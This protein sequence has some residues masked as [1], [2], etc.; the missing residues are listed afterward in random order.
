MEA[1]VRTRARAVELISMKPAPWSEV[2]YRQIEF[3]H[4]AV[5]RYRDRLR[6]HFSSGSVDF[7]AFEAID[8]E[9]FRL[10]MGSEWP[11]DD[12]TSVKYLLMSDAIGQAFGAQAT[13]HGPD[14]VWREKITVRKKWPLEFTG[15]MA[16]LLNMP[17]LYGSGWRNLPDAPLLATECVDGI[18]T[19]DPGRSDQ[20]WPW[21]VDGAWSG[22]FCDVVDLSVVVLFPEMRRW[23]V[24]CATH[25][26]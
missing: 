12:A 15:L 20:W 22:Y 8:A 3:S 1:A 11:G 9:K 7:A 18:R 5:V 17:G 13:D 16:D 25:T 10:A 19:L 14:S 6:T 23:F 26:D 4:G 24:L 2:K 21:Q